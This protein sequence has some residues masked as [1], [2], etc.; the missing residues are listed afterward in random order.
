MPEQIALQMGLTEEQMKYAKKKN[1]VESPN[2][3][4]E[5]KNANNVGTHVLEPW[6]STTGVFWK[7][8]EP[9]GDGTQL[10]DMVRVRLKAIA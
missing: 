6:V 3:E 2:Y 10:L 7:A 5:W 1:A 9:F 8:V 4:V